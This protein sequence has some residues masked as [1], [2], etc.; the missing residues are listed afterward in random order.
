M[1]KDMLDI[2]AKLLKQNKRLW[3]LLFV[4]PAVSFFVSVILQQQC[5]FTF[6]Y[7]TSTIIPRAVTLIILF[8][9]IVSGIIACKKS[10]LSFKTIILN[11]IAF[12][13]LFYSIQFISVLPSFLLKKGLNIQAC[14]NSDQA[15]K[16]AGLFL[17]TQ[18]TDVENSL[19]KTLDKT[20]ISD[21]NFTKELQGY[22]DKLVNDNPEI[23]EML[24]KHQNLE[25]KE[26][27]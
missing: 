10:K 26:N 15:Q 1:I 11:I 24:E 12:V 9:F 2:F 27:N 5:F 16:D 22:A 3:I 8:I 14:S 19:K 23:K 25:N 6:T 20:I 13:I 21:E 7:A 4:I 18:G 17:K